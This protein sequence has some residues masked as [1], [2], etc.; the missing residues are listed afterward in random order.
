MRSLIVLQNVALAAFLAQAVSAQ[1]FLSFP[2]ADASVAVWHGWKYDDGSQHEA[3]DYPEPVGTPI[4]AAADGIAMVSSQ[5]NNPDMPDKDAYGIFVLI[6][7]PNNFSTLYAH[8]SSAAPGLIVFSAQKRYNTEFGSWTPV[9]KGDIIG[10]VGLSGVV[11]TT[12]THLHFEVANNSSG[13]YS[14]HIAN[15]TDPYA[16]NNIALFYPPSGPHFTNCGST[17]LWL[18]CPI[19]TAPTCSLSANPATINQGQS[20]TLTWTTLGSPTAASISNIGAV[21][22]TGGSVNVSPTVSTAYTLTVSNAAGSGTCSAAVTVTP[23]PNQ[24]PTAGFVMG[25]D[26]N[27]TKATVLSITVAPGGAANVLFDGSLPLSGDHDGTV[28][29]WRWMVNG[30]PSATAAIWSRSFSAGSYEIRL[31]V[32]DN[33][34]AESSPA[35]VQVVVTD[36]PLYKWSQR[37]PLNQPSARDG[38]A[39]AYDAARHEVVLFGG[40]SDQTSVPETWVWNGTNWTQKFPM[41]SPGN[42]RWATMTY[43]ATRE[44]VV[45]FGGMGDCPVPPEALVAVCGDTWVWNGSSW[46]QRFPTTSPPRRYGHSLAY[47]VARQEVVLFGGEGMATV[48]NPAWSTNLLSDTWVWNGSSWIQRFPLIHPSARYFAGMEYDP[49]RQYMLLTDG[50]VPQGESSDETWMWSSSVWSKANPPSEAAVSVPAQLI[51]NSSAHEMFL[52]GGADASQWTWDG[53]TWKYQSLPTQDVKFVKRYYPG[54]AYD[55]V[56]DEVIIFGGSQ[57]DYPRP[58]MLLNDTWVAKRQ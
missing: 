1:K 46:I 14:E 30:T 51:Y 15:R 18:T 5:P 39:M 49:V 26:G 50:G 58:N 6:R 16:L 12:R 19:L 36:G 29:S 38:V 47:N 13:T 35:T 10:Y 41:D 34:G 40:N 25:P 53:S 42:R 45:L 11:T 48:D 54:I 44:E 55:P 8:M 9:K 43:D 33:L 7:H 21:S 23:L 17:F 52:I 28:T 27:F 37:F 20:S 56:R 32:T 31:T 4:L 57:P 22:P 2:L 3:V 24:P